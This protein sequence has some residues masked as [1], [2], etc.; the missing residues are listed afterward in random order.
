MK[1]DCVMTAHIVLPSIDNKPATFSPLLL[2]GLLRNKWGFE[3]LIIT[4]S[5]TM[6]AIT[7]GAKTLDEAASRISDAAIKAFLAG[8]DLLLIGRVKQDALQISHSEDLLLIE[9]SNQLFS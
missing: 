8:C 2:Q 5:L 6:G 7:A 4:D 9:K 1:T 3:G